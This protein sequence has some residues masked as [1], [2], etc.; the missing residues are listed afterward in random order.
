MS[1]WNILH[2]GMDSSQP[3]NQTAAAILHKGAGESPFRATFNFKGRFQVLKTQVFCW[4]DSILWHLKASN[5][6]LG[7]PPSYL[8]LS[9][10][11]WT[12]TV[13]IPFSGREVKPRFLS[14]YKLYYTLF[15][16]VQE[17][18]TSDKFQWFPLPFSHLALTYQ[19]AKKLQSTPF[20]FKI[21]SFF[22][23]T[24]SFEFLSFP[25]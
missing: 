8:S 24:E 1:V 18:N 2:I 21:D 13:A 11:V 23:E 22:H 19:F 6:H 3:A 10:P 4:R 14:H 16:L 20:T 17:I 15:F 9:L 12:K 7:H 5:S 25:S